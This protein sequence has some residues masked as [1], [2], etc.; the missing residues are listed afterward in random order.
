MV[1]ESVS[2][3]TPPKMIACWMAPR[4]TFEVFGSYQANRIRASA[5]VDSGRQFGLRRHNNPPQNP[6]C[7]CKKKPSCT[8]RVTLRPIFAEV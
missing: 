7:R 5:P 6:C 3:F 2:P 1:W 4:E 8:V